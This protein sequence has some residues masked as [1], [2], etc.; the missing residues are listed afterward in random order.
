MVRSATRRLLATGAVA[1]ALLTAGCAAHAQHVE[2]PASVAA[3]PSPTPSVGPMTVVDP[4]EHGTCDPEVDMGLIS[5][6]FIAG[7]QAIREYGPR[8][9]PDVYTGVGG[10]IPGDPDVLRIYITDRSPAVEQAFLTAS[11]LP[12]EKVAFSTSLR[13]ERDA[14][15]LQQRI[16]DDFDS[17][18]VPRNAVSEVTT[19]GP[20]ADGLVFFGMTGT[21]PNEAQID[22]LWERYG[23][24]VRFETGHSTS[25]AGPA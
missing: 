17:G 22:L 23:P 7:L 11:G 4:A 8:V 21:S 12:A 6:E 15:A 13:S 1:A 18:A 25:F 19:F 5:A 14:L 16:L 20:D 2:V 24:H 9:H 3:E 10:G